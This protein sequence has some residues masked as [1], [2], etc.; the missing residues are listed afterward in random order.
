M[1]KVA[2]LV[3]VDNKGKY[4]LMQRSDHPVF[5]YDPDL[6][7]GTLEDGESPLETMI[8]EVME[9]AG[10]EIDQV[11]VQEVYAGTDY[12]ARG[13]HIRYILLSFLTGPR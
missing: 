3:I 6:P 8:R 11:G 4:L 12:S 9:E 13:T 2:K 7:G 5:G 1:K 10:V